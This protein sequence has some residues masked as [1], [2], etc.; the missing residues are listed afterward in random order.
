[1]KIAHVIPIAKGIPSKK[2]SYF[3]AKDVEA[4]ALV[5]IP[6]KNRSIPAIVD[7]TEEA[8]NIKSSIRKSDFNLKKIKAI[9]SQSFLQPE[10]VAACKE[11]ANYFMSGAGGVIKSFV[12]QAVLD[13]LSE[14]HSGKI[15]TAN[16]KKPDATHNREISIT[17]GLKEE[18]LQHYRSVIRENFA[19]NKSVFFCLPTISDI[20]DFSSHLKKGI[21][22]YTF[23]LHNKLPKKKIVEEWEKAVSENHPVLIIATK[24]FLGLPRRD[25]SD[26]I[27]DYEN[28]SAYKSQNRPYID[29]RK[30]VEII[31]KHTGARLIFGD[32][33]ARSETVFRQESGEFFSHSASSRP[34][35]LSEAEQ[36]LV[37][38]KELD[39][40]ATK[41]S[42]SK[43]TVI[44]PQLLKI[45]N[46]A[47]KYNEKIILFINRRGYSPTTTCLDCKRVIL[48]ER[49]DSPM[50][51]HKIREDKKFSKA[52]EKFFFSCHKCLLETPATDH[53]PYCKGWQLKSIGIGLQKTIEEVSAIAPKLKIFTIDSDSI[54]TEKQGER[55]AK[56]FMN[57]PGSV[58][59]G[60]EL[61]FSFVKE[62]VERVAVVSIDPLF[63][64]P[65]F[66]I[67]E[68]IFY[69]L[70][71][72]RAM[73]KKT[74][75]A[76]TR[77]ADKTVFQHAL[78][79]NVS[80]FYKEEIENRKLFNYPPFKLLIKLIKESGNEKA[81]DRETQEVEKVLEE[82]KPS[83]YKAF[84]PK[85]KNLLRQYILI[86]V[87]PKDW[88]PNISKTENQEDE[89][90]VSPVQK[91]DYERL[92]KI[93]AS[94]SSSWKV[95]ID[96]ESLL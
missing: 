92:Y 55:I 82:W 87:D 86:K 4:G 81:L 40:P 43:L 32:T 35:V 47:Y 2:L 7:S 67:N 30:S 44:S 14:S 20:M 45:L 49:C 59:I 80:G 5:L 23:T 68:R 36:I 91:R 42:R 79:G 66:R 94:L 17:Y 90:M 58:L 41:E 61:I 74:F 73:A 63:T 10:F 78:R 75:L 37:N 76:Q 52:D 28:S 93:L 71:R 24:S 83:A 21:E 3:T 6:I 60:T 50:V 69:L 51:L 11:I 16:N 46:K 34:R 77:M 84:I 62:P 95:D 8:K 29:A 53:C 19:K 9:K 31:S 64:L 85:V 39:A 48:C 57:S 70:L 89:E 15:K 33:F 25:I 12:P 88:P 13:N 22:N 38:M 18:R 26:I 54:K 65:E 56:D 27:L 1:M 96:P 72:L